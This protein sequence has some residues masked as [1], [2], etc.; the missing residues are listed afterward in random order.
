MPYDLAHFPAAGTSIVDGYVVNALAGPNLQPFWAQA[1]ADAIRWI[2]SAHRL[3]GAEAPT[4]DRI[5]TLVASAGDLS[6]LVARAAN[7]AVIPAGPPLRP[8]RL[9]LSRW[10]RDVWLGLDPTLR[11]RI[12]VGLRNAADTP[13]ATRVRRVDGEPVPDGPSR[14][15][16]QR[17]ETETVLFGAWTGLGSRWNGWLIEPAA[18]AGL[19]AGLEAI[20]LDPIRVSSGAAGPAPDQPLPGYQGAGRLVADLER[21]ALRAERIACAAAAA[22]GF[23]RSV[24]D[25]HAAT[26][27]RFAARLRTAHAALTR[28]AAALV[29]V[30]GTSVPKSGS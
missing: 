8:E 15:G 19:R 7:G 25:W 28:A 6:Q 27:D 9:E 17:L 13:A 26:A 11:N 2:R 22:C 14:D 1:Y 10:Y 12:A 30:A 29:E 20:G 23:D 18:A 4:I 21:T 3:A 24:P 5:S 16:V